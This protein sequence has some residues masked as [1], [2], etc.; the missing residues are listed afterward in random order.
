LK[1]KERKYMNGLI[2][3]R[4]IK[5][6]LD[7]N[8]KEKE[9]LK[10]YDVY[11]RFKE[12]ST[13]MWRQ[14]SKKGFRSK[15]EAEDFLLKINSQLNSNTFI[16]PKK[17]TV[18]EYLE[19]WIKTYV[20]CNLKKTTISSYIS[21]IRLHIIPALGNIE[22]QKLT[23]LHIDEFYAQKLKNGRLNGK[24]GLSQK[25]LMYIHR[26]LSEALDH[27]IKKKF[28]TT[29][30]I[31]NI[32]NVPKVP[33]YR[34][35]IYNKNE[36]LNLLEIIKDT[37]MECS[38]ALA[39]LCGLRRGEVLGLKWK[40]IDF[41]NSV[42]K[43]ARQL[44]PIGNAFEYDTPKS[45]SSIREIVAPATV[46]SILEKQRAKQDE[47]KRMLNDEY[48]DNELINCDNDGSP[49]NPKNFS[50]R[51]A[52]FLK[53]N[54]LKHIRFHDLRHSYASLMLTSGNSLK[55]T[56]SL[57]GHSTISLTADTYTH[58]LSDLKRDA[59]NRID[60]TLHHNE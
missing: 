49:I 19:E 46:I 47:Y 3:T 50:K 54:N 15:G 9:N 37:D 17:I 56:S 57:L 28:L 8:G 32:T 33:R 18:R 27:A 36:I 41:T 6:G 59:A 58:V 51:F 14:T 31:K 10:V 24:G 34:A 30:P 40:D 1:I 26:I 22:L 53:K 42:I 7:K 11:Y 39:V 55:V 21:I 20:E 38:I 44:I 45:E 16:R 60:N 43:I 52:Y 35:E 5:K 12:P 4:I 48:Q 23:A 2:K 29:N 13:G 25:S